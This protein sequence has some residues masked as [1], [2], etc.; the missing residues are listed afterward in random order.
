MASIL[1][2][3]QNMDEDTLAPALPA[4]DGPASPIFAFVAASRL[5]SVNWIQSHSSCEFNF[6]VDFDTGLIMVPTRMGMLEPSG[7]GRYLLCH[8]QLLPPSPST[9]SSRD[10]NPHVALIAQCDPV[11]WHRRFGHLN[12]QSFMPNTPT[13]FPLAQH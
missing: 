13:V 3:S 9:E 7:N 8:Q 4:H 11:M 10:A 12:M 5:L 2:L 6:H 1:Q